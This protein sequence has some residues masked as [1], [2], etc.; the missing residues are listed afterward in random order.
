MKNVTFLLYLF[1]AVAIS[2]CGEDGEPGPRGPEGPAGADGQDGINGQ[3][4]AQGPQGDPG[5]GSLFLFADFEDEFPSWLQQSVDENGVAD[6]DSD[7]FRAGGFEISDLDYNRNVALVAAG[8]LDDQFTEVNFTIESETPML[9]SFDAWISS[10]PGFDYLVWG[11][12]E[13]II[14]G[15]SGE[16][17]PFRITMEVPA[18]NNLVG[19][20]YFKDESDFGGDDL[21]VIDNLSIETI[22]S[23]R[24]RTGISDLPESVVTYAEGGIRQK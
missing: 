22:T 17:G 18:G 7:W 13:D 6:D 14:N 21:G 2:S 9:V 11:Y 19:I 3:D 15:I 10:E 16:G 8:L 20:V 12:G 1:L 5:P 23:A 24:V 4:G